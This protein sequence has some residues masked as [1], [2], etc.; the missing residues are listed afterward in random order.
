MRYTISMTAIDRQILV[1]A[2]LLLGSSALV[3]VLLFLVGL[4]FV[5]SIVTPIN[6]II[7]MSKRISSGD[8]AVRI[9]TSRYDQDEIG[10]LCET[11][12]NMA[13]DLESTDKMKNDFLSSVSHELRTPLTAIKGWSE[14]MLGCSKEDFAMIERGLKI[15]SSETDRL[16]AMVEELLAFRVYKAAG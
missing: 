7:T 11:I 15:I 9:D 2:L 14:T 16:S 3:M 6:E 5:K 8:F 12:N 13:S 4:Y 1:V 10:E